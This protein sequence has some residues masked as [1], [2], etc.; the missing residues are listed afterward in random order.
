MVD[1]IGSRSASRHGLSRGLAT[2]F[3]LF[4]RFLRRKFLNQFYKAAAATRC[5]THRPIRIKVLSRDAHKI[6]LKSAVFSHFS[7]E[8]YAKLVIFHRNPQHPYKILGNI[9]VNYQIVRLSVLHFSAI[10]HN[11]FLQLFQNAD[12][13]FGKNV[14]GK[15]KNKHPRSVFPRVS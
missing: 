5:G 3:L 1:R 13:K 12:F 8:Y 11:E 2:T 15:Q 6:I 4:L 9:T 10:Y 14:F 7:K